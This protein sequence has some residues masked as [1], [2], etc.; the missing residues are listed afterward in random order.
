MAHPVLL[1]LRRAGA[2]VILMVGVLSP[3]S[4]RADGPWRG[5]ILDA[6]TKAPL[7]G[8]VVVAAWF[9]R[10]SGFGGWAGGGFHDAE[11]VVTGAD[12]RFE[13]SARSLVAPGPGTAIL[14]PEWSFFKPGYGR[15]QLAGDD[16]SASLSRAWVE[17]AWSRIT[18]TGV[19]LELR[20][21]ATPEERRRFLAVPPAEV[22]PSRVPRFFEALN[23]ERARLGFSPLRPPPGGIR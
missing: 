22:P 12:G 15:W 11:E 8:V 3:A 5:Q 19:V 13:I 17:E 18:T 9:V 7:L 6:A 2:L 16:G 4:S 23:A 20:P 10:E 14:G 1:S 21:L